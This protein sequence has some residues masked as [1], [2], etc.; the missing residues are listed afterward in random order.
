M[1]INGSSMRMKQKREIFIQITKANENNE[2]F[3]L[4]AVCA[5]THT[6]TRTDRMNVW[7]RKEQK[8]NR[9]TGHAPSSCDLGAEFK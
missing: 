9:Y 1:A 6:H 7:N 4:T 3:M 2:T 8:R 5:H